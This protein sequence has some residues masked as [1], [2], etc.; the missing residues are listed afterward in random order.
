MQP[1]GFN[2]GGSTTAIPSGVDLSQ[3][4]Q[5]QQPQMQQPPVQSDSQP[6]FFERL[7]PT[8]GSILGGLVPVP[9]LDVATAAA[10]GALGKLAENELTHNQNA[11]QGVGASA[12]EGGLGQGVGNVLGGVVKGGMGLLGKFA[13]NAS[14]KLIQGQAIKGALDTA[15]ADKLGSMGITDLRQV[16]HIAPHAT[17]ANGALSN[18]VMRGLQESNTGVDLSGL[19]QHA[20]NLVAENQMQLNGSSIPELNRTI[21]GALV[22]A[23]N[24]EDVTQVAAKGSAAPVNTFQPGALRNVLPENAFNITQNFEKLANKAYGSAYDKMGSVANPD[25]LAKY[26]IFKG[27]ADHSKEAAFG[28]ENPLPLSDENKAQIIAE[29]DPIKQ[30]NPTAYNSLVNEV[31]G[32][33]NVQ[34][35][36]PIQKPLVDAHQA[37][38]ATSKAADN[39]GGSTTADVVKQVAPVAGLATAG[40]LG[41]A[42]GILPTLLNSQAADRVGAGTLSKIS[43]L[44]TNPTMQKIVR[45][46]TPAA[47]QVVANAPNYVPNPA[48]GG[49]AAMNPQMPGMPGQQVPGAGGP[50]SPDMLALQ[51]GLIGL[52]DPYMAGTYAPLVQAMAPQLQ[53]AAEAQAALQ[54]LQGT[55]QQAGG[56]QG[57]IGGLLS[58][59]G[60]ALTGGPASV[61]GAQ[62][63][64]LQHQLGALGV[65][66][67]AVPQLTNTPQAAAQGFGTLQQI[68][69]AM[70]GGGAGMATAGL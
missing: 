43:D 54:G 24:P 27:L 60:G 35:L 53:K 33:Q 21:Q 5:P 57:L 58:R 62:A 10:G 11:G 3:F 45:E 56:G 63:G 64:Q 22:K 40:P 13:G 28:G 25:Q 47:T 42:A 69:N 9:G 48:Q 26:N 17:G 12:L 52:Q 29:L 36:R 32:A 37:L 23:V 68:I 16:G 41:A 34:D 66:I 49:A 70:G 51:S 59:L 39:A 4:Q 38:Q 2:A 46:G 20:N 18:G 65:P 44:L 8:A 31:S 30:I 61:Y 50:T 7:L 6:N 55:F 67:S 1:T 14:N 19:S 15:T